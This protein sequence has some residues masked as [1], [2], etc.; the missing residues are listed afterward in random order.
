VESLFPSGVSNTVLE[1]I[2]ATMK[3]VAILVLLLLTSSCGNPS[4]TGTTT[5]WESYRI[6]ND[7]AG[8]TMTNAAAAGAEIPSSAS[9][10][11]VDLT[12]FYYVRAQFTSSLGSTT[13]NCRIE[14]SLNSGASWNTLVPN[15]AASAS[16]FDANKSDFA[17]IPSDARGDVLVRALIVGNGVLDPVIGYV[18]IDLKGL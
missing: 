11:Y 12:N 6:F 5:L 13:I 10:A 3:K 7:A 18:G 16:A 9:R 14:Y 4:L 17:V 15:F 8:V 1:M 2:G